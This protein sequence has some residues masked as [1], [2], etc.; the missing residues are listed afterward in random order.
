[1]CLRGYQRKGHQR[2]SRASSP[3][4]FRC[5][6]DREFFSGPDWNEKLRRFS[7]EHLGLPLRVVIHTM[8]GAQYDVL[9]LTFSDA[10]LN[11]SL[12]NQETIVFL[13]FPHVAQIE[14]S[15]LR[16]RRELSFTAEYLPPSISP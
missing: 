12:R 11:L 5:L 14:I 13:P 10:G 3:A 2:A 16:D 1:M 15:A 4:I 7:D 9:G 8:N 6:F